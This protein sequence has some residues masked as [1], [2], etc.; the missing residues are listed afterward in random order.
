[1]WFLEFRRYDATGRRL[2]L[3]GAITSVFAAACW[4][5]GR[6]HAESSPISA[7][8]KCH[9]GAQ[10]IGPRGAELHASALGG[11]LQS[12]DENQESIL[13][14]GQPLERLRFS[15]PPSDTR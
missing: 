12:H 8:S 1:M 3:P 2:C 4:G 10:P 15:S 13:A 11:R 5:R 6:S 7:T 14:R 9:R